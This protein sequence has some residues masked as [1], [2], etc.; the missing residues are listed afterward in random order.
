ML[1]QVAGALKYTLKR[2][3]DL[4]ARYGGEEFVLLLPNTDPTG[5]QA[6]AELARQAV[7][8]LAIPHEGV[9]ADGILS[10]SLGGTS[11]LLTEDGPVPADTLERSDLQLYR[12]K[13]LGRNRVCWL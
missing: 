7:L 4:V 6:C 10:I 11:V 2:E 8:D 9:A 13:Q 5:G 1:T 3:T 12:A